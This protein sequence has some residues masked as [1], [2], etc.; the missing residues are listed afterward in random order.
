VA[1]LATIGNKEGVSEGVRN[2]VGGVITNIILKTAATNDKTIEHLL[3]MCDS[4]RQEILKLRSEKQEDE[5]P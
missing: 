3:S 1:C 4:L 2:R 5:A